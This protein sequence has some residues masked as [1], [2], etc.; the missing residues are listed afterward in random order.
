MNELWE[1]ARAGDKQAESVVFD[2]LRRRFLALARTRLDGSDCEDVAHDACMVVLRKYKELQPPF[3]Y[4]AWAVQVLNYQIANHRRR[5]ATARRHAA[6]SPDE[7][8]RAAGSGP[9]PEPSF[10]Q[11]LIDCV[12]KIAGGYRRYIRVLNLVHQGYTTEEI[13]EKLGVSRNNLYVMVTRGRKLLEECLDR[14][15]VRP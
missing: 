3:K 14:R 13:C 4:D 2:Q 8:E 12:R 5:A 7:H 6:A 1:Q 15:E 10:L 11:A 9:I